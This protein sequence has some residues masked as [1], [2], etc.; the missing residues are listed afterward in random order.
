MVLLFAGHEFERKGLK[1]ILQALFLLKKIDNIRLIV[2]GKGNISRYRSIARSLGVLDRVIFAGFVPSVEKYFAAA[3][4]FVFPTQYEAFSLAMLEAAA[5]GLP[6][7]VT[8]VNGVEELVKDGV[9][10]FI[11]RRN[12][13]D[14]A[15]KIQMLAE[16]D[17]LRKDM[18]KKSRK[19]AEKF[20]WENVT[21]KIEEVYESLLSK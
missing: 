11:I 12:A 13:A 5:S 3:D 15:E 16:D 9:N 10:G 4:I 8:N 17:N 1:I 7:V 2:I 6:L 18:G 19:I 14:I 21:K 20:S